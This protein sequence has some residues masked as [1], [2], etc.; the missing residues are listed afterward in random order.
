MS[1]APIVSPLGRRLQT[2]RDWIWP[3]SSSDPTLDLAPII[4]RLYTLI[5]LGVI[6]FGL[7]AAATPLAGGVVSQGRV[8][9]ESNR[10]LVQHLEGG[11][12]DKI[13]VKDGQTVKAGE[14]LV[15]LRDVQS[16]GAY[17]AADENYWGLR[18]TQ[19]RL[20]QEGRGAAVLVWPA[21]LK[22]AGAASPEIA[23]KMENERGAFASR[24]KE[25]TDKNAVLEQRIEELTKQKEG[26]AAQRRAADD[27]LQNVRGELKDMRELYEKGLAIRSRVSS[28]E[29]AGQ[30]LQGEAGE[31]G[32]EMAR[33]DAAMQETRLQIVQTRSERQSEI[34]GLLEKTRNDLSEITGR[35]SSTADVLERATVRAPLS[36][37]VM[38]LSVF[39]P[40][41]VVKPGD[42][43]MQIVPQGDALI[44]D[45]PI[46]LR[47]ID[48]VHVGLPARVQFTAFPRTA[49]RLMGSVSYVSADA[50]PE[51][52]RSRSFYDARVVIG[53][54]EL[55]RLGALKLVPGMPVEVI[56]ETRKRTALDYLVGPVLDLFS[57]SFREE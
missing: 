14:P 8:T 29:R 24:R 52:Q 26:A 49:P 46:G 10:K 30:A 16:R 5:G 27:Q 7:W 9:V 11:V 56:V 55:S 31:R 36:G 20:E 23:R 6:G 4:R 35:R 22:A 2:L 1:L 21:D 17:G 57:R 38:G 25:L 43:L 15:R 53:P 47:D 48:A 32:G 12:V 39:S 18:A 34:T 50:L 45:A 42:T 54:Q 37:V 33:L 3:A 51:S 13:L 40:G 28:L 41:A 19:A 44:I